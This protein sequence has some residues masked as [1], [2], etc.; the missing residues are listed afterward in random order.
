MSDVWLF[1]SN[2][3]ETYVDIAS[4]FE[5]K[6]AARLAHES[7]TPDPAALVVGWR[8]RSASI[9]KGANLALAE[10]FTLLE[11]D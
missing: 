8:A 10:A 6:L 2:I 5:R 3:A 9:G 1:A 7:Q 11:L 4:G